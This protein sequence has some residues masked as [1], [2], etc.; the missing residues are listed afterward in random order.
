MKIRFIDT[1]DRND[2]VALLKNAYGN[3]PI[4]YSN[5]DG[6]GYV[7]VDSDGEIQ[8]VIFYW[9]GRPF[10]LIR[11]IAVARAYRNTTLPHQ[12]ISTVAKHAKSYGSQYLDAYTRV[13]RI[14]EMLKTNKHV[15]VTSGWRLRG[16]LTN[17]DFIRLAC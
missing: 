15:S 16:D 11:D 4:D 12:L 3:A 7:A 5:Y 14:A 13:P 8:G 1:Y 6:P 17:D 2:I 9:L 10:S